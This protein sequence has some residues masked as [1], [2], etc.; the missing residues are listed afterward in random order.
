MNFRDAKTLRG[1]LTELEQNVI[2]LFARQ[3]N[4]DILGKFYHD[5]LT[6]A[7]ITNVK[8]GIVLTPKH[9]C[10]LFVELVDIRDNDVFL[11]PA[12]GTGS[13]LIA[14]MN[15]LNTLI[16]ASG[17]PDTP[18]RLNRVKENQL[19]GFETNNTMYALSVSNMLFRGDGKSRVYYAD[20]FGP[21]ADEILAEMQPTIG[22]V[23]PPYGGRD[24][25]KYPTKKEVQFLERMLDHCSRYGV[26]IAPW[27]TFI[28]DEQ[29]RN[30]IL[31]KHNLIYSINMPVNLFQPNASA[32]TTI[33]VFRTH[34][35]HQSGQET[36]LLDLAD[37]GF[38]LTKKGRIDLFNRW[39]CGV[40][41]GVRDALKTGSGSSV[42]SCVQT[43]VSMDEEW[44]V[45]AHAPADRDLLTTTAFVNT[46]KEYA[47]FLAR[48]NA[49]K[50]GTGLSDSEWIDL[51]TDYVSPEAHQTGDAPSLDVSPWQPFP[52]CNPASNRALFDVSGVENKYTRRD[53]E[54]LGYGDVL[55]VTTSN[56]NNG[57]SDLCGA[58]HSQSNVLT[59]DSATDGKAFYQPFGFVGSD[60]VEV[61]S[62]REGTRLN[63]WTAL[64]LVTLCDLEMA[65][66]GY[67]RKRA[68]KRLEQEEVFL[69][70]DDS[71]YVDWDW[72]ENFMR[73]LPYSNCA[74]A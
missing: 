45:Q 55:W 49:D 46:L 25:L 48:L 9:V 70:V 62:P 21:E 20:F 64:F 63:V 3:S 31:R 72:V 39:S 61:L 53:L 15:R 40:L 1:I 38:V 12:C 34:V 33:C 16:R 22:F 65:R 43:H 19:L 73:H 59:V 41:P 44:L 60:H 24:T 2:P 26:I 50:L 57:V 8:N 47:V 14:A 29:I 51:V 6:Y 5:F 37:D 52:L 58:T 66:Y 27:S 4:Y 69:P 18:Q 23:N 36:V 68:Q 30:R 17:T 35:A 13:F 7:G 42:G 10:E 74:T 67:G 56:K 54:E 28:G 71:G 11:D 32:C